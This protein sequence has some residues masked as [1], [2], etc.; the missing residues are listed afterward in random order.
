MSRPTPKLNFAWLVG[1]PP[2][3]QISADRWCQIESLYGHD[4]PQNARSDI[5]K[6]TNR[7][8]ESSAFAKAAEPASKV[9]KRVKNIHNRAVDLFEILCTT[10]DTRNG[11]AAAAQRLI[12]KNGCS[13]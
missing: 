3:V 1:R 7:F 2:T 8:V 11:A 9:G 12:E 13:F 5:E 4:I 6:A 10:A